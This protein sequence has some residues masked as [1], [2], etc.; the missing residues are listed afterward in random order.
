MRKGQNPAKA[1]NK[2]YKPKRLGIATLVY[3]PIQ[4]GYFA[5]SLGI[6]K[7]H[8]TSVWK[9]T[10]EEF[11]YLVF[12]NG[13][14][15]EIKYELLTLQEKGLITTLIS[16]INNLG[17]T[18]ALNEI[19]AAM[20][21][22]WICY[23]DSDML[24][25]PGWLEACWKINSS[26]PD[27]GMIG[28]QIIYPDWEVDKGNSLF[29]TIKND[30]YRFSQEKPPT[31]IT[32]EYC[33]ARGITGDRKLA[34]EN[35]LLDKVCNINT[36]VECYLGGNS[37]QQFLA[38]REV[39]Q[40]ILPLPSGLQLSREE[41]T[42]QDRRLDELNYLHLTTTIP[43]LYHMGNTIDPE[44]VNE[45]NLLKLNNQFTSRYPQKAVRKNNWLF[46]ILA[47]LSN[48]ILVRKLML[49]LYSNLYEIFSS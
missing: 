22:E 49:R 46:L 31:W 34:Y 42:Y 13:S 20:Q 30:A 4:E 27:I 41:D 3:I 32:E 40:R 15:P 48:I 29:R 12:D 35:M 39:L 14:C 23:A 37:H 28:A 43:Y 2:A 21:N 24:F 6:F 36:A 5:Q 18:G 47:K 26:F 7:A 11:D 17:K 38:R 45:I 19:L 9:Y 25:R 44:I 10:D 16:S 8:L 33:R 1:G